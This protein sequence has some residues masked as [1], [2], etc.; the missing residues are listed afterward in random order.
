MVVTPKSTKE[1]IID[2]S[3]EI[4]D[5]QSEKIESL[6]EEKKVMMYSI[7]A[8]IIWGVCF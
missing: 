1:E 7:A 3:I 8:L 2:S 4:I 6:K 5:T